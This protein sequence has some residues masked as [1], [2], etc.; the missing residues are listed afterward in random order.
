MMVEKNQKIENMLNN[1]SE[2]EKI[3]VFY[4][5]AKEFV[6][7]SEEEFEALDSDMQNLF[8]DI[9]NVV[10]DIENL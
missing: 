8:E 3:R 7:F 2:E 9:S 5:L 10:N 4:E 6:S 1:L